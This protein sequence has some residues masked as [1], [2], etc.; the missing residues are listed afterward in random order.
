MVE[1]LFPTIEVPEIEEGQSQLGHSRSIA[2]DIRT[3]DFRR[4]G[5][6]KVLYCTRQDTYIQWCYKTLQTERYSC[7]AY[8]DEI[9]VEMREA[10][11]QLNTETMESCLERT[12]TEALMVHAF[13]EEVRDFTFF[14]DSDCV[15]C[16][17]VIKGKDMEEVALNLKVGK[18]E[19]NG[20]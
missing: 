7:L 3:G 5:A 4:D 17:F 2:W 16:Y 10:L 8:P 12:I 19:D 6:N 1:E 13:T 18:E 9:G 20:T 14:S 15:H 11:E